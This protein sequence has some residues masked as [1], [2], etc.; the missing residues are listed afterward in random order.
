MAGLKW[1]IAA[2][3]S[4]FASSAALAQSASQPASDDAPQ[5]ARVAF[6]G[7]GQWVV[8][9]AS[10]AFDI[11]HTGLSNSSAKYFDVGGEVGI[12]SF[13]V[14]NLSIGFDLSASDSD[15]QG[16]DATSLIE[17]KS[18]AVSG[19]VRFGFNVLLGEWLSL[20]PRLTLGLSSTHRHSSTVSAPDDAS[21][22]PPS[23]ASSLGPWLNLY[24]PLLLQPAPHFV[25]GFGP[26][27][28]HSFGV[29]R[30]GPYDGSQSTLI[31]AQLTVGGWWGGSETGARNAGRAA[32]PIE[33]PFGDQGHTVFTLATSASVLYRSNSESKGSSTSVNVAPSVDYFLVN[34]VSIGLDMFVA[35]DQG[36]TLGS[37]GAPT[38]EDSMSVGFAPRVGVNLPLTASLSFWPQGEIGYGI[39]TTNLVSAKGT[40]QHSQTRSWVQV[41]A[42]L[43]LHP[44]SHFFVGAGPY[45]FHEL[46]DVDQNDYENEATTL[47]T[48]LVLGGWL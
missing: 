42:P 25:I 27:V 46:S 31:G 36:R 20:Y 22:L 4:L 5:E 32:K 7:Q 39:V 18:T 19:G 3:T 1:V 26:R 17:T 15:S 11:S 41:S 13:V 12:D 9:G 10:N 33:Q 14:R 35:H 24:V 28:E 2:G 44:A 16:Y 43:L 34:N 48:S 45:L 30:G 8:M 29:T 23:S 6:G 21:L 37:T 40:N 47:G 38:N